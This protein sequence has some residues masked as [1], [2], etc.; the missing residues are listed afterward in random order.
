MAAT[1]IAAGA[2]IEATVRGK[3]NMTALL[4]AIDKQGGCGCAELVQL[5]LGERA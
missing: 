1:L 5:L 3:R 4:W 2:D